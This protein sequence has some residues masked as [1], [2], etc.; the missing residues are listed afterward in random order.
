[1]SL[2]AVSSVDQ[3]P[4]LEQRVPPHDLAAE[5]STLGGMLLSPDAVAEAMEYVRGAD[6]YSPKHEIIFDAAMSLFSHSEPVDAI[7]VGDEIAKRGDISKIGGRD[8]LHTLTSIVP[9]AANAAFYAEIVA[10]K[11]ILRRLVDASIRIGQMSY[12]AE[13]GD[14]LAEQIIRGEG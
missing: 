12:A 6:F 7:T 13:L 10:E 9:T 14:A 1:M 5:Q 4:Q 11:A 3:V 2:Q 8:Y